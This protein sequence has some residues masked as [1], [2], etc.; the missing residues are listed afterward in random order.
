MSTT[1]DKR[2]ENEDAIMHAE[3]YNTTTFD[4]TMLPPFPTCFP[5]EM[6]GGHA[7]KYSHVHPL[8]SPAV[9]AH[10]S[11]KVILLD[12]ISASK[13]VPHT[14]YMCMPLAKIPLL[15]RRHFNCL[16]KCC[17]VNVSEHRLVIT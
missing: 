7:K 13:P 17:M 1:Y 6:A 15:R 16:P 2:H 12:N 10:A 5:P 8:A 9:G 4:T 11:F 14:G 3:V